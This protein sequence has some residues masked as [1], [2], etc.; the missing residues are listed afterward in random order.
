V[1]TN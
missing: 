1:K